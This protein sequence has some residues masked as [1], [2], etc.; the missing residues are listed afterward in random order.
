MQ[1][2]IEVEQLSKLYPGGKRSVNNL[3]FSVASGEIFGFLGPNGAGKSATVCLLARLSL[4]S[5]GSARVGGHDVARQPAQVR[6]V[7]GVALQEVGVDP[8]TSASCSCF[9]RAF[10]ASTGRRGGE[11]LS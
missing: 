8:L 10:S 7:A 5:G 2:A 4:P 9:R 1:S 3:S 11:P 6:R